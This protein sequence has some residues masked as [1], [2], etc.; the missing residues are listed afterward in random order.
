MFVRVS[1]H[2]K[3]KNSTLDWPKVRA[4]CYMPDNLTVPVLVKG[5][6]L[7]GKGYNN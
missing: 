5:G 4:S 1:L 6:P 3:P 2:F 7:G